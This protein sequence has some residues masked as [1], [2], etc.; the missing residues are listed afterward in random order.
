MTS[1]TDTKRPF[2]AMAMCDKGGVRKTQTLA[3]YGA[4]LMESANRVV[5]YQSDNQTKLE[6][7]LGIHVQTL[8]MPSVDDLRQ[9]DLADATILSPLTDR[10]LEGADEVVL[11]DV[12]GN[13]VSRVLDVMISIDL[14][15]ALQEIGMPVLV[16]VP[17]TTDAETMR[18][19]KG[20]VQRIQIAMP[21]AL[22]VPVI[23]EDG[24]D[25]VRASKFMTEAVGGSMVLRHPRLMPRA[26][27]AVNRSTASPWQMADMAPADLQ[28]AVKLPP[29][30]ARAIRG[31]LSVWKSHLAE[32]FD[33]LPFRIG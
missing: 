13:L 25:A 21:S 19:A 1:K 28:R 27:E 5:G 26:L 12:G 4:Y 18:I 8:R 9:D 6:A 29:T 14:D 11:F 33:T 32:A 24:G 15:V 30:L 3:A 22:I 16:F 23:C 2:L 10:L 7:S 31:D 20:T 17:T